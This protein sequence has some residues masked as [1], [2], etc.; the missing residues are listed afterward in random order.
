MPNRV[1][2]RREILGI[3]RALLLAVRAFPSKKKAAIRE[4][5]RL[6]FRETAALRDSDKLAR[7]WELAVRGLATMTKYSEL[8][9]TKGDWS[10]TLE[11]DPFGM[12]QQATQ[13]ARQQPA[14]EEG[15]FEPFGTS[16][17]KKLG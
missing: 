14:A 13:Q 17:P 3:Y 15:S 16:A 10:V 8:R 11:Q 7:A 5:I 9:D 2:T 4:D 12:G 1:P 6:E